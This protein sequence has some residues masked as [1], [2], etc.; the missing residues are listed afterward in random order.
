MNSIPRL[1][2]ERLDLRAIFPADAQEIFH[3]LSD[4]KVAEFHELEPFVEIGQA[5][6]M[7]ANYTHWFQNDQAVRWA[8]VRKDTGS[9]I[10]TCCFDSFQIKYQSAN[11]GYNL[12]SDQWGNGFATE[13]VE[14]IVDYAFVHGIVGAVNRIQAITVPGNLASEK[15]LAKLGF[16]KEGLMRQYGFW[17]NE[18]HDMNLFSRL[19]G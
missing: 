18:F 19:R 13:A 6:Q 7:I 2:T 14:A 12:S 4:V 9:L 8:I 16:E 10:G 11:L 5:H 1:E 15:V 3:L 17:Q